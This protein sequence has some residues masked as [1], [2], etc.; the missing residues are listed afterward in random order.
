MLKLNHFCGSNKTEAGFI[1]TPM[2]ALKKGAWAATTV[3]ERVPK[4]GTWKEYW[5]K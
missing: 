3:K 1:K 2:A 4:F 5:Q